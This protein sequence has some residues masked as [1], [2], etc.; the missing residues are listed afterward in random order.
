ME[1]SLALLS[2][3][4][5]RSA[6]CGH[7]GHPPEGCG[8]LHSI[9][10]HVAGGVV[11]AAVALDI[12]P[13]LMQRHSPNPTAVGFV[14]AVLTLLLLAKGEDSGGAK[15]GESRLPRV[16]LCAIAIDLLLDG[17]VIGIGFSG[18]QDRAVSSRYPCRA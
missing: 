1:N 3:S 17:S 2:S 18:E 12:T 13:D 6:A 11:F 14:A 5:R 8:R 15:P 4:C 9:V 10:Q 16:Y 7:G